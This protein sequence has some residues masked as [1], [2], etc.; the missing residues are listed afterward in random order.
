MLWSFMLSFKVF[1]ITLQVHFYLPW[2]FTAYPQQGLG[3]NG[4]QSIWIWQQLVCVAWTKLFIF[5]TKTK[6]PGARFSAAVPSLIL[7]IYP[8][9]RWAQREN[10]QLSL[11]SQE[12]GCIFSVLLCLMC[13]P[14]GSLNAI[15]PTSLSRNDFFLSSVSNLINPVDCSSSIWPSKPFIDVFQGPG[16]PFLCFPISEIHC[17]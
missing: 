15:S 3:V 13:L 7:H 2:D 10:Q 14:W 1:W 8:Q 11:F 12:H 5:G 6:A 17:Q 4:N 9:T 16:A